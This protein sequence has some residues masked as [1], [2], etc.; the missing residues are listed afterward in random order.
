MVKK[1]NN[2]TF[3]YATRSDLVKINTTE[4]LEPKIYTSHDKDPFSA[5]CCLR[6]LLEKLVTRNGTG[7]DPIPSCMTSLCGASFCNSIYHA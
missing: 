7:L 3:G 1:E 2:I 5:F 4:D 6:R